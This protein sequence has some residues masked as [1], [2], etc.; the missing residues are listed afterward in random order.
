M[1][2]E[3]EIAYFISSFWAVL[4]LDHI[5][6]KLLAGLV[7]LLETIAILSFRIIELTSPNLSI[8]TSKENETVAIFT[9][10][11]WVHS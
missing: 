4:Q 10:F 11:L 2:M 9:F 7:Y 3:V 6:S 8:Y 5:Y 1:T